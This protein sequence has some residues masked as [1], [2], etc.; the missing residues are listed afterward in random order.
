MRL[1]TDIEKT[2]YD[3]AIKHTLI[4]NTADIK[5]AVDRGFSIKAFDMSILFEA[6][7]P[8]LNSLSDIQI[9]RIVRYL[10]AKAAERCIADELYES[11]ETRICNT[12]YMWDDVNN[13]YFHINIPIH[14]MF[15]LSDLSMHYLIPLKEY[16][17]YLRGDGC[18]TDLYGAILF[19]QYVAYS[20]AHFREAY[21]SH[22]TYE[23]KSIKTLDEIRICAFKGVQQNLLSNGWT[24]EKMVLSDSW[25]IIAKYD[26]TDYMLLLRTNYGPFNA[27][28]TI[29]ELRNLAVCANN[30]QDKN[31]SV[32]Y[33]LVNI[34]S[35][36]L[37]HKNDHVII[38]GDKM[39][40]EIK[41]LKLF[42]KK[43]E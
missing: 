7:Y 41:D 28:I 21:K 25:N 9:I 10:M 37:Q 11:D 19:W 13:E 4:N 35:A 30:Y 33:I 5:I 1:V 42:Q 29:E 6:H 20:H 12:T 27:G 14:Y 15:E 8:D 17:E 22:G 38:I 24:I 32:G 43:G 26:G 36:N 23:N 34:D 40:F 2:V 16:V 3:C 31:Y 18:M 39:T